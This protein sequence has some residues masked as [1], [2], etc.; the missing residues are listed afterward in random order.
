MHLI[1]QGLQLVKP[2]VVAVAL[3]NSLCKAP[4]CHTLHNPANLLDALDL[5]SGRHVDEAANPGMMINQALCRERQECGPDRPTADADMLGEV[6]LTEPFAD[7]ESP[8]KYR[9]AY[10]VSGLFL[11]R[12]RRD[13]CEVPILICMV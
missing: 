2:G 10:P 1:D 3:R 6:D 12:L 9:S 4:R 8:S 5:F 11:N 13:S 7:L